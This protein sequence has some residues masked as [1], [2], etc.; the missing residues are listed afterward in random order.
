MPNLPK[1]WTGAALL[2]LLNACAITPSGPS[3]MVLPGTGKSFEEFR[4]DDYQC[5]QFALLQTGGNTPAQTATATGVGT[6][7]AG[8]ALGAAAGAA[9]GGGQGAAVGSGIGLAA[10]GLAGTGTAQASGMGAQ[11]RY[12]IGY[13]QCMYAKG[14]KVPVPG[15]LQYE[16][17]QS[18]YPPPPP[19]TP[20]PPSRTP[21]PPPAATQPPPDSR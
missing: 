21:P 18:S 14:H 9:I 12:D 8:A 6:A 16:D 19:Q 4:G 13:I 17:R 5:R 20:P 3:V 11:E 1:P 7:I 10:G 15:R 2:L